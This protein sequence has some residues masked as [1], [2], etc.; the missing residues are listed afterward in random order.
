MW[1]LFPKKIADKQIEKIRDVIDNNKGAN[2]V[3]LSEVLG[4]PKWYSTTIEPLRDGNGNVFSALVI[5]RDIHSIKQAE[6]QILK[7]SSAVEQS[8]DGIAMSDCYM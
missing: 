7:L 4:Q 6:E 2:I 1:D 8:I 5:A 3:D